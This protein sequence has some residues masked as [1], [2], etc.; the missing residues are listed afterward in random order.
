MERFKLTVNISLNFL[1]KSGDL[2]KLHSHRPLSEQSYAD[3]DRPIS[4]D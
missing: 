2:W 3:I 4:A 1:S